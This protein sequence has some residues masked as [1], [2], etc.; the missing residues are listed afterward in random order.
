MI[1]AYLLGDQALIAKLNAM[2]NGLRNG[3]ARAVTR[4]AIETQRLVQQKLSGSVLKVRTGVL[5]SSI[6]YKVEQS[7]TSVTA[8]VGTNV[9]YAAINEFGGRTPPH[10]ILPKKA[11]AL[12]FELNGK[13]IFAMSVHH[14]GSKIPERSFLRSALKEMEPRITE[15]LERAVGEVVH[16]PLG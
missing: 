13:T 4:L 6:N 2:P 11:R 7:S 16:Q 10:E 8:T 3:I 12:A 14:P 5:R 1:T 9:K 15:E